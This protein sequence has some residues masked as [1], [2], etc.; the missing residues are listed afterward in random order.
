MVA[1]GLQE[2]IWRS[3]WL[4]KWSHLGA[5]WEPFGSHFGL[6]LAL[7]LKSRFL[8]L[9]LESSAFEIL[10]IRALA[11]IW[12]RFSRKVVGCLGPFAWGASKNVAGACLSQHMAIRSTLRSG[13]PRPKIK[14]K[15]CSKSLVETSDATA[16]G[17]MRETTWAQWPVWGR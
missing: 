8:E 5:I 2:V 17:Q 13:R 11:Y 16:V 7:S 4:P 14:R 6:I 10:G 9:S 1:D 3:F 15:C 12:L